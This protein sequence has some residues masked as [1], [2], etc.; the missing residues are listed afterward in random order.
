MTQHF[1]DKI[2]IV[3]GGASGIGRAVSEELARRSAHVVLADVAL[4]RAE[5]AAAA[6]QGSGGSAAATA[7]D[8][9][10]AAAVQ[11]VVDETVARHGRLD[12]MF[13]NAGV[14]LFGEAYKMTLADWNRLLDVNLH[15]VVHGIVAAYEVMRRQGSGHIVNTASAAGIL[16]TPGATA[17]ATTKHALVGLS[18]SLR[19]EAASFGV[20]VSVVCPGFIDTPIKDAVKLLDI[21]RQ[22]LVD[23]FPFRMHTAEYCALAILRGVERNQAI[24]VVTPQAKLGWLAYR[25]AP[26]AMVRVVELLSRRSPILGRG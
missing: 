7:L 13:N 2:A 10:D 25:L 16:P 20:K 6:I 12:Y 22:A 1:K 21:D 14:A 8:V 17:Y 15:G 11:R 18:T 23:K 24:I 5:A 9:T 3:T 4:Q 19:G 26:R